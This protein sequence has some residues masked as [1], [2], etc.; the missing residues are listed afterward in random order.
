MAFEPIYEI[1]QLA[2]ASKCVIS[3]MPLIN[4]FTYSGNINDNLPRVTPIVNAFFYIIKSSSPFLTHLSNTCNLASISLKDLLSNLIYV[5]QP[6]I[7]R[8]TFCSCCANAL[9]AYASSNLSMSSP[10]FAIFSSYRTSAE[11]FSFSN[12]ASS[13]S[14]RSE[15]SRRYHHL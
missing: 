13:D 3:V 1:E 2:H 5:L 14:R 9:F 6:L 4:S 7:F 10:I 12:S 11:S 15:F 8:Y